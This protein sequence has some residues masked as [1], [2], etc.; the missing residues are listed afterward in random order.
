V[1]PPQKVEGKLK[2][3]PFFPF[4]SER[5]RLRDLGRW[6]D[7]DYQISDPLLPT[8]DEEDFSLPPDS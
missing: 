4:C 2:R 5:C 8:D 6:I 3:P 1:K 7:G